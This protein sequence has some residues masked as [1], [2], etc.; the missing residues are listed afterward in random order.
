MLGGGQAGVQ[1]D[2]QRLGLE[3]GDVLLL[4]SDGLTDMLDDARISAV[5]SAET[6]PE[7]ACR[8]LVSEANE[9]GGHDNITAVVAR[10]D[11]G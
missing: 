2:V 8:R 11:A 4:C 6:E 7:A 3:S 1:V 5:L 10:I 9:A